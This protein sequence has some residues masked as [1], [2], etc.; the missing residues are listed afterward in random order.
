MRVTAVT[1]WLGPSLNALNVDA[2][3]SR[4][5]PI[6]PRSWLAPS[7]QSE[8]CGNYSCG[9]PATGRCVCVPSRDRK[10]IRLTAIAPVAPPLPPPARA[11][12]CR[13]YASCPANDLCRISLER[14]LTSRSSCSTVPINIIAGIRISS[15]RLVKRASGKADRTWADLDRLKLVPQEGIAAPVA[16][17]ED[18]SG[19]CIQ[20]K[21]QEGKLNI[22]VWE[23][24]R[25]KSESFDY[26][27]GSCGSFR[28]NRQVERD[29]P[30]IA[31]RS[32]M[33]GGLA[34]GRR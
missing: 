7:R 20:S 13:T 21:R 8:R 10:S 30:A 34:R 9:V 19:D 22:V 26:L 11:P 14:P 4:L 29:A 12:N 3:W 24:F 25:F 16:L 6:P 27:I 32:Q 1:I 18:A 28:E 15:R 31:T 33:L 17:Q 23:C 2:T 5:A